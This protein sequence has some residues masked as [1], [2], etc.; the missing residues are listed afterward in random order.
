M[1]FLF[2]FTLFAGLSCTKS[3]LIQANTNLVE[4]A[5]TNGQWKVTSFN[6]NGTDKTQ[7]FSTYSFQFR[8]NYSVDA[9]KSGSIEQSGSW[10]AN[11]NNRTIT[12]TFSNSVPPISLLNGTWTIVNSTWTS[13]DASLTINGQ[14]RTLHLDK[15]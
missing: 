9:I 4:Q 11:A 13:V 10:N 7:D 1:K 12:S 5:M 2:V 8:T 6:D 3:A 14:S 15:I